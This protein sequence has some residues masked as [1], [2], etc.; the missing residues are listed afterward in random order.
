MAIQ[1]IELTEP[2]TVI[3]RWRRID[4]IMVALTLISGI[5]IAGIAIVSYLDR[6]A[7]IDRAATHAY[8]CG[9]VA[10]QNALMD[11]LPALFKSSPPELTGCIYVRHTADRG[12]F[13]PDAQ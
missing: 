13:K 8:A 4:K 5:F 12:G 3:P 6:I 9:Y 1:T 10:G 7:K 11:K 2:Q